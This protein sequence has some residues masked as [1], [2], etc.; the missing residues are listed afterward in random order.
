MQVTLGYVLCGTG[1][2]DDDG[3]TPADAATVVVV[4]RRRRRM[5]LGNG[6]YK[7]EVGLER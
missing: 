7:V 1:D 5:I 3:F 4:V 6:P 2:G